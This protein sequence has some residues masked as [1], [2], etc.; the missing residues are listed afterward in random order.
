M[1]R[2]CHA[3]SFHSLIELAQTE[4]TTT[5]NR[6][7]GT[8]GARRDSPTSIAK[9]VR[10]VELSFWVA[11]PF[12]NLFVALAIVLGILYG[13]AHANGTVTDTISTK[14]ADAPQAYHYRLRTPLFKTS[15]RT[16]FQQQ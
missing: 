16:I 10:P 12:V 11:V 8:L 3:Y 15:W 6:V 2:R 1:S 9:P 14:L 13:K 5:G 4:V 7:T